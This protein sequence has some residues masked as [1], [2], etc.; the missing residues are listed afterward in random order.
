MPEFD[1][2]WDDPK[3]HRKRL[4]HW[5]PH[6]KAVA[7][8]IGGTRSLRYFTLCARS[9]IDVF[10]LVKEGLLPFDD[11]SESIGSVSFCE[12]EADQ[13][14]EIREMIGREDS[15]FFGR[16]EELALFKDSNF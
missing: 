15:G 4:E 11:E 16:I 7:K 12:C 1:R 9:M 13:F 3:K 8:A 2:L 14:I 10:M 6:W 5:L